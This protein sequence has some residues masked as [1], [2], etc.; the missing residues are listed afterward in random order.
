[1]ELLQV[2]NLTSISIGTGAIAGIIGVALT[3][4]RNTNRRFHK[5]ADKCVVEDKFK[6]MHKRIN[7]KADRSAFRE[8][9]KKLDIIIKLTKK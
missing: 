7:D 4:N 8:F 6:A 5:K 9:D 2:L 3:I 1:M